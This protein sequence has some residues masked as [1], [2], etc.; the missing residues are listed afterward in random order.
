MYSNLP[1]IQFDKEF[2]EI[3]LQNEFTL[4][5]DKDE[6][7]TYKKDNIYVTLFWDGNTL[8]A[9]GDMKYTVSMDIHYIPKAGIGS[10]ELYKGY[11][12][13][14]REDVKNIFDNAGYSELINRI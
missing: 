5:C 7:T 14:N 9:D 2:Q 3:L 11:R 6:R 4:D 13:A 8:Q 10:K 1:I 12:P